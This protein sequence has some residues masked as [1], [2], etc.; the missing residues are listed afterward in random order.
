MTIRSHFHALSHVA[1]TDPATGRE[2]LLLLRTEI[3]T[4]LVELGLVDL[5]RSVDHHV[6]AL[7]VLREGD[8]VTDGL[9]AGEQ[10]ADTVET[11]CQTSVRRSTVLEGVDDESELIFSLLRTDAQNLEHSLLNLRI[12]DSD[13]TATEFCAVQHEVV[14]IGA[15]PF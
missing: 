12:M 10:C 9:L 7:V 11:K 4:E 15:N 13:G 1:S 8:E 5:G 6:T 14:G 2:L 3:Q